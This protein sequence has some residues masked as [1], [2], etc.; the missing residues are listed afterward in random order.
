MDRR[1]SDATHAS[2]AGSTFNYA[3]FA[4][5]RHI[6]PWGMRPR[7]AMRVIVTRI[8]RVDLEQPRVG[9]ANILT[10]RDLGVTFA[11]HSLRALGGR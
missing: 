3:S 11:P 2:R 10:G 5:E 8:C 9:L 4:L 1:S 6:P 7:A